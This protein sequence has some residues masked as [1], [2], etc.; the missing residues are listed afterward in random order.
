MGVSLEIMVIEKAAKL[1]ASNKLLHAD[2]L[3]AA[4]AIYRRAKRYESH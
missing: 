1:T 2:K 3:L 4:L